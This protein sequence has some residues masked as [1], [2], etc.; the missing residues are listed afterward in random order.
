MWS[1][2]KIIPVQT[3]LAGIAALCVG[4]LAYAWY[5]QYGPQKQQPCPLCI[6]QRYAYLL[7][8]LVCIVG[9]LHRKA[10]YLYTACLVALAGAAM[11]LWQTLKGSEMTSCRE[12]PIG[13]F[14]N[15]LPMVDW[16]PEY[17]F[18]TGGCADQ[19]SAFGI[20]VP[21]LSLACCV[22]LAGLLGALSFS[23][24]TDASRR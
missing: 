23:H 24:A 19:Y 8:A 22:F 13:V 12:D 15:G 2:L 14:V 1:K 4:L 11:A 16:W 5:L 18:A 3:W 6:L 9:T 20:P 7:L 17:L 10:I 21:V